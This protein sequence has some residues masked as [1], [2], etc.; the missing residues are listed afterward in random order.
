M[1]YNIYDLMD[2]F[3][4]ENIALSPCGTADL[5]RIE[6]LTMKKIEEQ[7]PARRTKRTVRRV[8]R[9]VLVAAIVAAL[10]GVTDDHSRSSS[11]PPQPLSTPAH[12]AR[13]V[14]A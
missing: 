8:T 3:A 13:A 10:C 12:R 1:E 6:E 5:R 2:E 14:R 7:T 11:P 9:T 4:D